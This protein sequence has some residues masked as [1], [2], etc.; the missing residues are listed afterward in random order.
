MNESGKFSGN[1]WGEDDQKSYPGFSEESGEKR[2]QLRAHLPS[3]HW[4]RSQSTRPARDR[5]VVYIFLEEA[6]KDD[7]Q[8]Q[9]HILVD[10]SMIL[11]KWS[12][13]QE[14]DTGG[15]LGDSMHRIIPRTAQA[16][17]CFPTH[18]RVLFS[19]THNLRR[20]SFKMCLEMFM[21][22]NKAI[23]IQTYVYLVKH[24]TNSFL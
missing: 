18:P 19:Q 20:N 16:V 3:K 2:G 24:K 10:E 9:V 11:I 6:K 7:K 8:S 17:A 23:E 5:M 13:G 22:S 15:T 21:K 4:R 14:S 1:G 12:L